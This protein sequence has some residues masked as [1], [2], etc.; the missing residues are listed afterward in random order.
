MSLELLLGP[1]FAGKSSEILRILRRN[2]IIGRRTLCVTNSIDKRYGEAARI[3]SHNLEAFPAIAVDRLFKLFHHDDF[4]AAECIIIEEAQFF[5]DLLQFVLPAVET[6][7]RHVICVGLDGD[8]ER[9]PFGQLMDLIP[10]CNKVTKLAALCTKCRDGTEA[11]FTYRRPGAPTTQVNDGGS[12]QYEPLCRAHFLEEE[13]QKRIH[14]A[15]ALHEFFDHHG[16]TYAANSPEQFL[17]QCIR[18]VGVER[19]NAIAAILMKEQM[20]LGHGTP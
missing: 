14:D 13:I 18:L 19:G 5:P 16:F 15:D 9:R 6:Y 4:Q 2:K 8:S 11:I 20:A 1:M 3:V 7:G 10:Y 12:D 17:D